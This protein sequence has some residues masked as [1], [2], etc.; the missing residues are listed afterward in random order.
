[1]SPVKFLF[2]SGDPTKPIGNI[3]TF[4]IKTNKNLN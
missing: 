4:T 3:I 2:F 1:M